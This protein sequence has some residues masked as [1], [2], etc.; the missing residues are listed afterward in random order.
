MQA[1]EF[2]TI[3]QTGRLTVPG[4]YAGWEGKPVKV[5]VLGQDGPAVAITTDWRVKLVQATQIR[6]QIAARRG[7]QPL[8]AAVEIIRQAREERDEQFSDLC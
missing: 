2:Q 6:T 8:P 1:I 7:N 3:F 4:H 5:I